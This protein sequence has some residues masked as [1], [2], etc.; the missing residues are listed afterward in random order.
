MTES[1]MQRVAPTTAPR[2]ISHG[3]LGIVRRMLG[4]LL[5]LLT[6]AP[7]YRL[8]PDRET[9]LAGDVTAALTD[10]TAGLLW[11][12]VL[13]AAI[14]ALLISRF[15]PPRALEARIARIGDRLA[16]PRPLA[17]ALGL[18]ALSGLLTFGFSHF[19][20][21]GKP[22]LIDA[23]A[24]LVHARYVA[25]GRLAGPVG[26]DGA[27][28]HIQNTIATP[29]GWVSQYPPGHVLLLALGFKL[30]MV[31]AVG[32]ILIAVTVFFTALVAE[33]LL[34]DDRRV[35]RLGA[36][37]VAV[38]PFLIGLAG[39]YMNHITAAAFG[40][41]AIYFAVRTR[42]G[43]IAWAAPTGAALAWAFG[44][45]PLAGLVF[46]AVVAFGV[47]AAALE[48]GRIDVRLW[49]RRIGMA[50]L[51]ALPFILALTVYNHHFFGSPF[52]FGYSVAHGETTS[53]GFH[54][55][56]WGNWYGPIE[57]ILYTSSDLLA[58][59]LNLLEAPV[60]VVVVVG[61]FLAVVPRLSNGERVLAAWA[62]LPVLANAFYWHHGLFMGPR[63]LNEFAPAWG[64]LTAV[65]MVGLVRSIPGNWNLV[66]EG[67]SLRVA[68]CSTFLLG[69]AIGFTILAPERLWS[70]GGDWLASARLEVPEAEEPLLVFVHGGWI[71]RVGMRLAAHGMRL[72]SVET[73]LRQNGTCKAHHFALAYSNRRSSVGS[74][75]ATLDLDARSRDFPREFEISPGNRIRVEEGEHLT[76][77]CQREIRADR[78]GVIDV[79]PL[80]WQGDLPGLPGNDALYVR[81][82]GPDL[83]RQLI[84]EL[85]D[86]K[87]MVLRTPGSSEPP[88]LEEY[89]VGMAAIWGTS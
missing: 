4:A 86:R 34:P 30:D 57:A 1:V 11:F 78:Y 43:K 42:D 3:G 70:Y 83:N 82:M 60:P 15:V 17:F 63:M 10:M 20:L 65:A 45:R 84:H 51:G 80:L 18:A 50:S 47:W 58:L 19:V 49:G 2:T 89:E 41:M 25:A 71:S 72:D 21:E 27:F 8:L 74:Q 28:W 9:G 13:L 55:D 12:G 76:E 40:T 88:V 24:Q 6:V 54:R 67:Y 64:L 5:V 56:P 81:D 37:F 75:Y 39:A 48:R 77:S 31:E 38:S 22:N 79:S 32:P 69:G 44:T 23:M 7:L 16:A 85:P 66:R 29:N 33:R 87:P 35:A 68:V 61:I 26:P 62:L 59:S 14:P 73:V 52:R 53:L 46:G 36:L